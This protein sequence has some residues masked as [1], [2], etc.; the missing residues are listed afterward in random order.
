MSLQP[1]PH[2]DY[3]YLDHAATSPLRPEART[4]MEPFHDV[5]YANPSGSHRFA[6]EVRKVIDEARDM[7]AEVI[8]CAPGEVVFTSG[9]TEGANTAILGAVRR[10]GGRAVCSAAEHHAVL[11]CVE[12]VDG[13]VLPVTTGGVVDPVALRETLRGLDNVS[14]VSTMAVNNEVGAITDLVEVSRAVRRTHP[15]S[16]LHTDAVQAACWLDLRDVWP[17]VDVMTLSAHKFGGPK[18]MGIMIVRDGVHVDPLILGGGQERD[19]RSGTHN[20]AGI[21]GTAVALSVTHDHRTEEVARLR[22]LRDRLVNGVT[23]QVACAT[24]TLPSD[25]SVAGIA[26]LCLEGIESEPL[27]FLLDKEDVC[28]SAASACASGAMEPSHVLAAMGVE[29]ERAKGA[30]RLSLGHTTTQNDIDRAV[31]AVTNAVEYLHE[32]KE[33]TRARAQ[34]ATPSVTRHSSESDHLGVE[35][36]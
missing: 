18:G 9:G 24:A 21:V 6:R 34:S 3:V 23:S 12:H 7:V 20:V 31:V 30:L 15:D 14:V 2:R 1:A 13:E 22:G 17:H 10:H 36:R 11:H 28:A 4:A 16:V 32:M 19:R 5:A 33:R 8:G 35:A 27:L 26:H 29:A 25:S